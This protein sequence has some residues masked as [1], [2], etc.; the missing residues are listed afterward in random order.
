MAKDEIIPQYE[1]GQYIF[2]SKSD[3]ISGI[4]KI[5]KVIKNQDRYPLLMTEHLYSVKY[6]K[7]KGSLRDR[8]YSIDGAFCKIIDF[9]LLFQFELNKFETIKKVLF[10]LDS[11]LYEKF[12]KQM[13][14]K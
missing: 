4:H 13:E 14:N 1:E 5:I 7:I 12:D 6:E 10:K 11:S 3:K 8:E 9:D 2:C